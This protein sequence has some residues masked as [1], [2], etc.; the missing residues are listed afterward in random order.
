MSQFQNVAEGYIR[1]WNEREPS[2]RMRLLEKG[3]SRNATYCDPTAQVAGHSDINTLIGSVQ[4][5]FPQFTFRLTTAP[6]GY[7]ERLRFSWGFGPQGLEPV[8]EGSDVLTLK[9]D[10]I[11][12]VIGFLDKVP[13]QV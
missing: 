11:E 4:A 3:W 6:N 7:G 9:G 5:R 10:Q 12:S 13:S 1:V 8:I 2:I